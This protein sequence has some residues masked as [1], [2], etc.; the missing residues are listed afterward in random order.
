[1]YKL[2]IAAAAAVMALTGSSATA[3]MRDTHTT[4]TMQSPMGTTTTPRTMDHR[5]DGQNGTR[6]VER[7]TVRTHNPRGD[8]RA[9]HDMRGTNRSWHSNRNHCKTWWSHGRKM[10]SCRAPMRHW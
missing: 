5:M 3:Q 8:M 6:T 1:M 4:T 9:R 2:A 10:R 7:T